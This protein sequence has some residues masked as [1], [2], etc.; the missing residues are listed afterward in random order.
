MVKK[1]ISGKSLYQSL[2]VMAASLPGIA[3]VNASITPVENAT[4]DTNVVYWH[5]SN[6]YDIGIYQMDA[7]IPLIRDKIDLIL[8]AQRDVMV[9]ASSVFLTPSADSQDLTEVRSSASIMDKREQVNAN[10]RFYFDNS[11]VSFGAG[12]SSE[13]DYRSTFILTKYEHSFNK[14]NTVV[15]GRY[16]V[17]FDKVYP[18]EENIAL[19]LPARPENNTPAVYSQTR[20]KESHKFTFGIRQDLTKKSYASFN[21]EYAYDRGFL[22]DPYKRTLIFG[23]ASGVRPGSSFVAFNNYTIDY[24]RR[25]ENRHTWAFV[26]RFVQYLEPFKSAL[27][28]DYRFARN[29]WG[30]F[31][32]TI[33]TSY[34]QPFGNG[35]EAI[36]SVRF[37]TQSAADFY[38]KAFAVTNGSP[39]PTVQLPRAA[40]NSSDYRLSS[41]GNLGFDLKISKE[42]WKANKI[43]LLLG[44]KRNNNNLGF[45]KRGHSAHPGNDYKTFYA[46][47]NVK[48]VDDGLVSGNNARQ[49]QSEFKPGPY[50][51]GSF[52]IKP[53]IVNFATPIGAFTESDSKLENV[54]VDAFKSGRRIIGFGTNHAHRNALT[55]G[56]ELGFLIFDNFE[57][58][59]RPSFA[60]EK[61]NKTIYAPAFSANANRELNFDDRNTYALS[62][63]ARKYCATKS[64]W[65]PFCSASIGFESQEK[66]RAKAF[67]WFNETGQSVGQFTL[68]G[69]RHYMT[70]LIDF[71]YDYRFN[72]W[73]SATVSAGIH[74]KQEPRDAVSTDL[75]G[76][77]VSF[78]DNH[79]QFTFPVN[80]SLKFNC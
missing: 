42:F 2:S 46:G 22:S 80:I 10:A 61:G 38:S 58:F 56:F 57:I 53:L 31:S 3:G 21:A 48:I 43:A 69:H 35:W 27:H 19:F 32:H 72:D 30:I 45:R 33:Q 51:Q 50:K 54:K 13:N 4:L 73:F 9:G 78:Q 26:G 52:S 70:A 37:Y 63:G 74:Y 76:V 66:T 15:Y 5:E 8:S 41:F 79:R 29:T 67:T 60:R 16:S 62:F 36:P 18:V 17:A 65:V 75:S 34:H 39:Y 64:R 24:D 71:G 28:L 11:N 49:E 44:Y 25:P 23:D 47:L 68:Q 40:V 77:A 14:N 1:N 20:G 7:A 6:R 59:A 12:Y 55:Y